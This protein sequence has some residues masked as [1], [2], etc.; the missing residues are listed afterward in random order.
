MPRYFVDTFDHIAVIDDEGYEFRNDDEIQREVRRTL[1]GMMNSE[2][3][4]GHSAH[5]RADVRNEDGEYVMTATLVMV[6]EKKVAHPVTLPK[7]SLRL[8]R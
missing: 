8:T 5:F 4:S 6:I 7:S 1:A 2:N 3:K